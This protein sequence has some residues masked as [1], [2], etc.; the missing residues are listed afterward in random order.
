[1][2]IITHIVLVAASAPTPLTA[3][4]DNDSLAMNHTF[5]ESTGLIAQFPIIPSPSF[6]FQFNL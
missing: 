1:M 5:P 3:E 2:M 4:C 6:I